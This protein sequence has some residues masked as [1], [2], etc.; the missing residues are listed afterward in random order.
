MLKITHFLG[1]CGGPRGE[2]CQNGGVCA[3]V[4]T[5]IN[6]V[7]VSSSMRTRCKC[8]EK[9]TGDFCEIPEAA[10][11]EAGTSDIYA[12]SQSALFVTCYLG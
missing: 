9:Y 5:N 10:T 11:E 1:T 12:Y 3:Y 6:G 2:V 4:S 8:P 7:A